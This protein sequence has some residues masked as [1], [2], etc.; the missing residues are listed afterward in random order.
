MKAWT[1]GEM[2]RLAGVNLQTIRYYER[3]KLMPEPPRHGSGYRQYFPADL[4]RLRFIRR[5]QGLGFALKEIAGLL[6]I[7]A[8]PKVTCRPVKTQASAKLRDIEKDIVRLQRVRINLRK[9]ASA[10]RKEHPIRQ[11]PI[12]AK[13]E[14]EE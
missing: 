3:R 6:E 4:K 10:C 9:L 13:L 5:A 14:Q 7:C 1:I 12:V 8:N 2:A 11:C